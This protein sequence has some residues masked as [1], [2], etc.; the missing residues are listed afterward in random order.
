M[1]RLGIP[2]AIF[3]LILSAILINSINSQAAPIPQKSTPSSPEED[4]I[5]IEKAVL[6]AVSDQSE[7]TLA[8]LVNEVQ[9][10]ETQISQDDDTWAV[11]YIVMID[12]QTGEVIP[13][14]PGLIIS[15]RTTAGWRV[16]LPTNLEWSALVRNA[17]TDI[18]PE[19]V[20]V[21]YLEMD[22]LY[23]Q[24][25]P[26]AP[27]DHYLL[28]WEAGKT[29]YLSRSTAHDGDIPSGNA[30]YSFDFYIPQTMFEL[31]AA[32]AGTVWRA[33]WD[34]PNGDASDAGNFIVL[35]DTTTTPTTYQ[36]YLHLAQDSI[37]PELRERGAPVSQGQLVGIA[38]DTGASTGHHLHFQVHT[39]PDSYWGRSVD[40]TFDDVDINGGRPRR[41][42]DADYCD[43]PGDV[44]EV[45]RSTYVS[46]N[47]IN[48]G[49]TIPPVGD[50][51]EPQTGLVLNSSTIHIEGWATDYESGLEYSQLI[52]FYDNTWHEIGEPSSLLTFA[53]DWNLCEQKVPDGPV[54]LA[55]RIWDQ[56]GNPA[57]G[58]PGLRHFTK[59]FSCTPLPPACT[60]SS[61]QIAIFSSSDFWGECT[62]L[63]VGNYLNANSFGTVGDNSIESIL[64]GAHVL[65]TL[66]DDEN[67]TGRADTFATNDP[68][69]AN[70][71]IGNNRA[72]SIK[73]IVR[74][75]QPGKPINLTSPDDGATFPAG[76]SLSLAWQDA[77]GGTQFQAQLIT[78]DDTIDS[79]W[80]EQPVW[81][82]DELYLDTG[83]YLWRARSR[84]CSD[85]ACR[86]TWSD[87][88]TFSITSAMPI[89]EPVDPPFTDDVENGSGNWI[90]SGL[91]NRLNRS[92]RA[93]S[94]SY[95]WYYGDQSLLHYEDGTANTGD[96]TSPPVNISE[97]GF[98]LS[99]WYRYD[100]ET[101]GKNFDQRWLQISIDGGPFRNVEQLFD[102][103]M[104][105][106]DSSQIWLHKRVDLSEYAN[107]TVQIRF[108]FETLD[109]L[110]NGDFEGWFIDDIEIAANPLP[111]C[112]DGDNSPQKATLIE[113]GQTK[114][115]VICPSGDV[116]Y[117]QFSAEAGD[118]ISVDITT[119][120]T[121][122]P[123]GLDLILFLIDGDS[124]TI[125]ATH[126]D[127]IYAVRLD[128][129]LGYLITRSG[130][131]FLKARL[132]AHPTYG[133]R[134]YTYRLKL[135]RDNS[136]PN[137]AFA[138]YQSGSFLPG[139]EPFTL[140]I[141]ADDVD[142]GIAH[143]QFLFHSND[144]Q[145]GWQDIGSDWDGSDGWSVEFDPSSLG[146]QNNLAFFAN[147]YDWAGNWSG[148][149]AWDLAI[150]QSPPESTLD[151]L[152]GQ[153]D[154]T[155]ISL[156]WKGDDNLSGIEHFELQ[157]NI[158][159]GVWEDFTPDP[160][161]TSTQMWFI[162][163]AGKEYGFRLRAIDRAGNI[164][165]YP[166]SAETTTSVPSAGILC[167]SPDAWDTSSSL[168]DNTSTNAKIIPVGSPPQT[169]NF[170]NPLST[171]RTNDEDWIRF[172]VESGKMY[173]VQAYPLVGA[174]AA[175]LE[176]YAEDGTT[177]LKSVSPLNLGNPTTLLWLADRTGYIFGRARHID[178][179]IIGNP[180]AY[181]LS[182]AESGQ[183]FLP[184]IQRK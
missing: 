103:V 147:V 136:K 25:A 172:Y 48:A 184:V 22:A 159:G 108:H 129:H 88:S 39:N 57:N 176:L 2:L 76:S 68:G 21:T 144:W 19:D 117:F 99:F 109:R 110:W 112:R 86:S 120:S 182:V 47:I 85:S 138:D 81:K 101:H 113:F 166:S 7:Y 148:I 4:V 175:I 78:P 115:K 98:T 122:Q 3:I 9:V 10:T 158:N 72:S 127:E 119:P 92:D 96:L 69:L 124:E 87:Y 126:D 139:S 83:T 153:Q 89:P 171:N 49:D 133:D 5:E 84:N 135:I 145:S 111:D 26:T 177:L 13:S 65:A 61:D 33:R 35:E 104:L 140:S 134:D 75:E 128:P 97:S 106:D 102:D 79:S 142:S 31:Y 152:A 162:S 130:T 77:G 168:N 179:R 52:A 14:E 66:Y 154:S 71:L 178:G 18:I 15:L 23:I 170:C 51:F 132:W 157:S 160:R 131:Y 141:D 82:L 43:W 91:W 67:L 107:H 59:D 90:A 11:S 56:N 16:S 29:V 149:A 50:L 165:A 60:P 63:G 28:P 137:A 169:H 42:V 38:D 20:K 55:I 180:I 62:N 100:T 105:Y 46:G 161:G 24:A 58:L 93:H 125:L 54:S 64:V 114:H 116:D 164:E 27:I 118:R 44:C 12:P 167:S 45:F 173:S 80:F 121:D 94:G 37:P 156:G 36:L 74:D 155:A 181:N 6:Q 174:S 8:F 17:P 151:D 73:V 70:S 150:D 41:S 32:K 34:V 183:I 123:D 146:E 40:I 95:S 53:Y 143:I 30:H 163:Q 1:K